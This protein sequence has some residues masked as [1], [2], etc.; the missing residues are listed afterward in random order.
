MGIFDKIKGK[1]EK[2]GATKSVA[3][4]AAPKKV[5]ATKASDDKA[6]KADAPV[7]SRKGGSHSASIVLVKPLF[8]EKTDRM[9]TIG[10]YTFLVNRDANKTE[11]AHAVRDIYGVTPTAVHMSVIKGKEVHFGRSA[12]RRS[13]RKK[14]IVTLKKGE[15]ITVMHAA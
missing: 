11:V 10:K 4:K 12:G 14:A 13:D 1:G 6:P 9:Q 8:T 7:A 5:S 15:K 2:K 3:K